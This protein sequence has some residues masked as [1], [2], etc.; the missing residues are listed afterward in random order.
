MPL[1]LCRDVVH[2][3]HYVP[4]PLLP[5]F[6]RGRTPSGGVRVYTADTIA[7]FLGW[8][9]P[10]GQGRKT[11]KLVLPNVSGKGVPEE[12]EVLSN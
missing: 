3:M 1:T 4:I 5:Y 10:G 8:R 11:K 7:D 12:P 2:P 6:V 9:Q